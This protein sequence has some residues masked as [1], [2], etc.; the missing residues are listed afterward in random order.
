M[1]ETPYIKEMREVRKMVIFGFGKRLI[2]V[3][4]KAGHAI[5]DKRVLARFMKKPDGTLCGR[6]WECAIPG[7]EG[8]I[9]QGGLYRV[10]M[11][12]CEDY[13]STPPICKF[14]PRIPHPNVFSSGNVCLSTL[15]SIHWDPNMSPLK[16]LFCL[17]QLLDEPNP[18]SPAKIAD[19]NRLVNDPDEYNRRVVEF[20]ATYNHD[21]V[22]DQFKSERAMPAEL[23]VSTASNENNT[24][25]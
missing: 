20:A 2:R 23:A 12:F 11:Y 14:T 16:I 7:K 6:T 5:P 19:A 4:Y 1:V 10:T 9:W 3:S 24:S 22:K 21:T 13:P 17:Q 15:S 25:E 8:T 18:E